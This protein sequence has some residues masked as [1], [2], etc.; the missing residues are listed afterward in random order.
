MMSNYDSIVSISN[1]L[2]GRT[3]AAGD[4][5]NGSFFELND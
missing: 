3:I 1:G 5:S 4:V 2:K